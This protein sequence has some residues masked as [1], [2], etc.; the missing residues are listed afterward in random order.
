MTIDLSKLPQ[1]LLV[2]TVAGVMV[3]IITKRLGI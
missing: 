2:A 3:T 1:Q